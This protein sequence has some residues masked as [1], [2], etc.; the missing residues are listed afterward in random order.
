MHQSAAGFL[1]NLAAELDAVIEDL[2]P[3]IADDAAALAGQLA[4]GRFGLT[5]LG[6]FNRGKSTL[7]NAL[8]ARNVLP[9]GAVPLT[10]VVTTIRHGTDGLLVHYRDGATRTGA[11]T[12]L[13]DLVTEAGNPGNRAG[14]EY[15]AVTIDADLLASGASIIDTPGFASRFEHNTASAARALARTDAAILVLSAVQPLSEGDLDL[16][17]RLLDVS[18]RTLVVVNRIDDVP[19]SQRTQVMEFIAAT[20]HDHG[21]D[22]AGLYPLSATQAL[23][24]RLCDATPT[25]GFV[26]LLDDLRHLVGQQLDSLRD[27]AGLRHLVALADRFANTLD[28]QESTASMAAADLDQRLA[29]FAQ[30]VEGQQRR[31]DEDHLILDRAIVDIADRCHQHLIA[32]QPP[33]ADLGQLTAAA[34]QAPLRRLDQQLDDL[35]AELVRRRYDELRDQIATRVTTDWTHAASS[36][37]QR[38]TDRTHDLRDAARNLFRIDLRTPKPPTFSDQRSGFYYQLTPSATFTGDLPRTLRR[39]LPASTQRRRATRH[40]HDRYRDELT[41]HAGRVRWDVL[42]RLQTARDKL[43]AATRDHL[44]RLA[45]DITEAARLAT[46]RRSELEEEREQ[47]RTRATEARRVIS[48]IRRQSVA[49]SADH[50]STI[51]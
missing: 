6:E 31:L 39:L 14:I 9:T 38:V 12:E 2:A 24:D 44:E 47:W 4:S 48:R 29:T 32:L 3:S 20:L 11:L 22:P 8:L 35:V 23:V 7:I 16:L 36:S 42:Q 40:A 25:N 43:V 37:L 21:H 49:P 50:T 30:V 33:D 41:K 10:T 17:D 45:D 13:T 34:Q 1:V 46:G 26:E 27:D 5:V 18:V 19:E 15:V 28:I 51:E